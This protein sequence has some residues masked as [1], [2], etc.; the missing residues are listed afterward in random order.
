MEYALAQMPEVEGALV[1][2]SP[3]DGKIMALV[4]GFD[5]YRSKFNRVTQAY[6]Q[7]GSNFKPFIY[8]AALEYGDTAATIYNDTPVVLEDNVLE[9]EWRP[10]NYSG[11]F[12]GPTRLREALVKSCLLYTSPSPRD[13]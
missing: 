8:S 11:R 13:S 10:R 2:L 9:D 1:S 3:L 4:G 6:R 7:P 12:F 5:F